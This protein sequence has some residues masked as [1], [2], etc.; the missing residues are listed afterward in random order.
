MD[1]LVFISLLS[2]LLN[3]SA[4]HLSFSL[5]SKYSRISRNTL[6]KESTVE[7]SEDK[8]NPLEFENALK[9]FGDIGGFDKDNKIIDDIRKANT[10]NEEIFRKYPFNETN[11]EL[12]IL[13]DCN[14]YY[15]GKY[16]DYFWH[17]NADQVFV[18]VP[19]NESISK[20]DIHIKFEA[21]SVTINISGNKLI[22]FKCNERIIP[23]GSFWI[24]ETDSKKQ[25]YLQLDLE[26]RY[27]MINWKNLFSDE[28]NSNIQIDQEG[29]RTEMLEKLLKA[30]KGMSKLLGN[31]PE[32]INE[33][34]QNKDLMNSI[35]SE[36]NTEPPVIDFD[37]AT[38]ENFA[39]TKE[40]IQEL[41]RKN[42]VGSI[43]VDQFNDL[44]SNT[45]GTKSPSV[46]DT[47]AEE[48]IQEEENPKE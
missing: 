47:T 5:K 22:D 38:E 2:F 45:Y 20:S 10:D 37:G 29:R 18:F 25:R 30:N 15:S 33:M 42:G 6:R 48:V 1:K 34:L 4:F 24:I 32:N 43:D 46:F 44:S 11:P 28:I 12:P 16:G 27:R 36:I 7:S 9:S 23:D 14:N 26:K 35:T 39:V 21:K 13:P 40:Y 8:F 41:L 17:Q 3:S 31:E 19:L